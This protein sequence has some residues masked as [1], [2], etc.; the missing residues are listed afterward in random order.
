[1]QQNTVAAKPLAATPR[2]RRRGG[3]YLMAPREAGR[4]GRA[5]VVWAWRG[6]RTSGVAAF[7]F[8]ING[9]VKG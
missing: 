2:L 3:V 9:W 8:E 5:P 4:G 1:M 6:Q 7:G